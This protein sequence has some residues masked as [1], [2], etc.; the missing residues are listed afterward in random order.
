M[1]SIN[2]DTGDTDKMGADFELLKNPASVAPLKAK[3]ELAANDAAPVVQSAKGAPSKKPRKRSSPKVSGGSFK[4]NQR[5][6]WFVPDQSD[7]GAGDGGNV[8][9]SERLKVI[10]QVRDVDDLEWAVRVELQD[11]DGNIKEHT[12]PWKRLSS[13]QSTAILDEL[14]AMGLAIS[15]TLQHKRW[16]VQYLQT[17]RDAPRARLVPATGWFKETGA[18]VLPAEI[19]GDAGEWLIYDGSL[20]VPV[21]ASGLPDTWRDGVARYAVGN[22]LLLLT[23]GAAFAAPLMGMAGLDSGGFHIVGASKKG[24]S[25]VCDLAASVYGKPEDYRQTW[26]AT[27]AGLEYT[28]AAFNHLPLLLDEISQADAKGVGR[29]VYMLSQGKGKARG[30]D[31][32]GV[33]DLT[34]WRCFILSNGENDLAS[35]IKEG[36]GKINAGQEVRFIGLSA[37][38]KHGAFDDLHGFTDAP[39][40]CKHMALTAAANHGSIGREYLALLAGADRVELKAQIHAAM[41]KFAKD[42]VPLGASN[43][44]SHASQYFALCGFA[45]ELAA[46]LGLVDWTTGTAWAAARVMYADWLSI[47]GG[48]GDGEDKAILRQVK[49]FFERYGLARFQGWNDE[50]NTTFDEKSAIRPDNCGFRK[51]VEIDAIDEDGQPR[52]SEATYYVFPN[53]W[54][55]VI[56]EGLDLK[57]AN[58]LLL[59]LGILHPDPK[60]GASRAERLPTSGREKVRVYMVNAAALLGADD[61]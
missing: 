40:L 57:R 48:A 28:T 18:F 35:V 34:R 32:G 41:A 16:L 39:A 11:M 61:E 46:S 51:T 14:T 15:F 10:A 45:G 38:R 23:L 6:V 26:S 49:L 25:T 54:R 60:G 43:Q 27:A 8:W 52:L 47:R 5:G 4:L 56:L 13:D 37:D 44:V 19:I 2:V 30:R 21:L 17:A 53:A 9:L 59:E 58:K 12:I 36:G 33:R 20:K 24:K 55:S 29:M 42:A 31:T 22:P 3:T 1:T 7:D 50:K